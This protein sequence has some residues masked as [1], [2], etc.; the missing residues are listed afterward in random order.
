[1]GISPLLVLIL[2][3]I[4]IKGSEILFIG[5]DDNDLSPIKIELKF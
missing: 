5:L 2:A 3:P 4:F 1:M